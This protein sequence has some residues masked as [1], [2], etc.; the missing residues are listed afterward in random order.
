MHGGAVQARSEGAG[1]GSE[2]EIRLPCVAAP[3][4]PAQ[5]EEVAAGRAATPIRILIADDNADAAD[6]LTLLLEVMGHQV[7]RVHDGESAVR[8]ATEFDP[9]L[10]LL[11]IGMPRLNGYEACQRIRTLPGG[12]ARVVAALTGWGQ[13]QD[14][15]AARQA[16]FDRHFTKPI[17]MSALAQLID[18]AQGRGPEAEPDR[19][20]EA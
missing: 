2:F 10:V 3:L 17:A 20:A 16:G 15:A 14:V 6:T 13:P 1:Q 11:D 4:Q 18:R 12:D 9:E 8:A 7:M 5:P 19:S